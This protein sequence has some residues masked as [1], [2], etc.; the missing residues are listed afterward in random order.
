[1][2]CLPPHFRVCV[3][4]SAR[5][6][7]NPSQKISHFFTC[8]WHLPV[9]WN[10]WAL[11]PCTCIAK[12]SGCSTA[13]GKKMLLLLGASAA[14][15]CCLVLLGAAWWCCCFFCCCCCFCCCSSFPFPLS[16]RIRP[17]EVLLDP[18]LKNTSP[19]SFTD[20]CLRGGHFGSSTCCC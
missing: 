5:G 15:W 18:R 20:A 14:P 6:V 10:V 1:M 13:F 19:V 7:S 3:D 12:T 16:F 9:N 8:F 2:N 11:R 17:Y 4:N